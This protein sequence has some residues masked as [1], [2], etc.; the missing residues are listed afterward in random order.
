MPRIGHPR[1]QSGRTWHRAQ[2]SET[3]PSRAGARAHGAGAYT[4]RSE[5]LSY[6]AACAGSGGARAGRG[7]GRS[8]GR[9]RW[10]R[11]RRMTSAWSIVA[12]R[13]RRPPQRGHARTSN[14]K[15]AETWATV[16]AAVAGGALGAV[17]LVAAYFA[18]V[19]VMGAALGARHIGDQFLPVA[20]QG[21]HHALLAGGSLAPPPASPCRESTP[22]GVSADRGSHRARRGWPS[23]CRWSART[24]PA[25]PAR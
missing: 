8:V 19:A 5:S 12:S 14:P 9:P 15:T 6:S 7:V 17:V 22:R 16:A 11:M 23:P 20:H 2:R 21:V 3:H 10:P 1:R 25:S 13:R 18:G 24:A 4:G